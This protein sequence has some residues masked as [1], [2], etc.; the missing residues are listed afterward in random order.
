MRP[1]TRYRLVVVFIH[2]ALICIDVATEAIASWR[3]NVCGISLH[4]PLWRLL[5]TPPLSSTKSWR[6]YQA[7]HC[8]ATSTPGLKTLAPHG[9]SP[10]I[11]F[12]LTRSSTGH[13]LTQS[14]SSHQHSRDDSSCIMPTRHDPASFSCSNWSSDVLGRESRDLYIQVISRPRRALRG[15]LT[16]RP[17]PTTCLNP[18][19][20]SLCRTT[21]PKS[22]H[23]S[24]KRMSQRP[25]S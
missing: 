21:R 16:I 23:R 20:T 18:R 22:P 1:G 7:P 13:L 2:K 12:R 8:F 9:G 11:H 15:I 3:L 14:W 10:F 24:R 4:F 19:R 17:H 6:C 25:K 5:H